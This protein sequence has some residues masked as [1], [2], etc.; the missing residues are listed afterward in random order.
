M[1]SVHYKSKARK[2][3][4]GQN[5]L[6]LK[7]LRSHHIHFT[8]STRRITFK[9]LQKLKNRSHNSIVAPRSFPNRKHVSPSSVSLSY[10]ARSFQADANI[11][12]AILLCAASNPASPSVDSAIN[13]MVNAQSATPTFDP[14]PSFASA[15]NAPL[16]TTRTNAWFAAARV[17]LMRSTALNVRD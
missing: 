10:P 6:I 1:W 11:L 15:M 13:A 5:I 4:G 8:S 12:L 17:S 2:L 9:L 16:V 3:H 14:R 7:T